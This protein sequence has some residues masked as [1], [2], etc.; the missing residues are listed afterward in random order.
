MGSVHKRILIIWTIAFFVIPITALLSTSSIASE[1]VVVLDENTDMVELGD[2]S[3]LLVDRDGSLTYQEIIKK[4]YGAK[5]VPYER[6]TINL[7]FDDTVVWVR[8]TLLWK[9]QDVAKINEKQW[10]IEQNVPFIDD[11]ELYDVTT[12]GD[13]KVLKAGDYTDFKNME[14]KYSHHLFLIS[15]S[16][17]IQKTIYMRVK[18]KGTI[19]FKVRIRDVNNVIESSSQHQLIMGGL[20]G[21]LLLM[22]VYNFSL[23]AILRESQYLFFS[24]YIFSLMMFRLSFEGYFHQYIFP[25]GG[26]IVDR[27]ISFFAGITLIFYIKFFAQFILQEREI[28][29]LR[30]STNIILSIVIFFTSMVYILYKQYYIG[31]IMGGIGLLVMLASVMAA[32]YCWYIGIKRA[33]YFV[34]ANSVIIFGLIFLVLLDNGFVNQNEDIQHSQYV[35]LVLQILVLSYA[36]GKKISDQREKTNRAQQESLEYLRQYESMYKNVADGLFRYS[37]DR[38]IESANPAMINCFGCDSF[39]DLLENF[40]DIKNQVFVDKK[41]YPE[42]DEMINSLEINGAP[43]TLEVNHYKKDGSTAWG[44]CSI[45]LMFDEVKQQRYYEGTFSNITHKKEVEA[46]EVA[47]AK[48]EAI[49]DAKGKFLATMSHEIRT[50]MNAIIGFTDIALNRGGYSKKVEGYFKRIRH[51]S[52]ILLGVIN[53]ILDFSKIEAGML[54]L[55]RVEFPLKDLLNKVHTMFYESVKE[56][57]V[58]FNVEVDGAVPAVLVGDPLRLSQILVNLISNAA[59][60]TEKGEIRVRIIALERR[61]TSVLIRFEVIDTGVGIKDPNQGHLF[62]AFTQ[63]DE[64]TTREYGGSGLGLSICKKMVD[65]HGGS[66][67]CQSEVGK[68]SIFWFEI[69]LEAPELQNAQNQQL[70][71][72]TETLPRIDG[73]KVL[74]VEDNKINQVIAV[75]LIDDLGGESAISNDGIE[76][77]EFLKSEKVDLIL[78]DFHMPRMGGKETLDQIRAMGIKTPV[79]ALTADAMDWQMSNWKISGFDGC[80]IKP[81]DIEEFANT[82]SKLIG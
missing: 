12:N 61:E 71:P 44:L 43:G 38:K 59:K 2:K 33:R 9:P 10:V 45:R 47:R 8:F 36:L 64:S 72:L 49:A 15:T 81:I 56:K 25:T 62:D 17:Y 51:S 79:V 78:M 26:V 18:S 14:I 16:P 53:D 28:A 55:E 73:K 66:I 31:A 1:R 50:P 76:A 69:D 37:Y 48:A 19:R 5:F 40:S 13:I 60:F 39:T 63:L 75:E 58:E 41:A 32:S 11:I 30:L 70:Y 24:L 65:L 57:G 74:I 4:E 54:E 68:G 3:D 34:Y 23:S 42:F 6:E 82:I 46:A 21:L 80:I 77:I 20:L 52:E 67:G 27:S 29:W 35:G 7:G 22:G